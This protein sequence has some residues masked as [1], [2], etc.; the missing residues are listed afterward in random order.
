[1]PPN[2]LP[3]RINTQFPA[4]AAIYE[5]Q[6]TEKPGSSIQH[7][8]E[9]NIPPPTNIC[10]IA[11]LSPLLYLG[12]RRPGILGPRR[13]RDMNCAP[14]RNG[15]R[16]QIMLTKPN[17]SYSSDDL[18]ILSRVL[19]EAL[20]TSIDGAELTDPAVQEL[21]SRLGKVIMDHFTAGHSAAVSFANHVRLLSVRR[22]PGRERRPQ[23]GDRPSKMPTMVCRRTC[24]PMDCAAHGSDAAFSCRFRRA[25]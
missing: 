14:A 15:F 6:P 11:G 7:C 3:S 9:K 23:L 20:K 21:S 22:Y 18:A 17:G 5:Q 2:L 19:E 1:M 16:R 4:S 24:S 13:Q 25:T 8:I 12:H 10:F